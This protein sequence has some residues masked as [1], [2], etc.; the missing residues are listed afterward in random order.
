MKLRLQINKIT[1]INTIKVRTFLNFCKKIQWDKSPEVGLRVQYG[2]EL[3]QLGEMVMFQNEGNYTDKKMF[4][5]ALA[6]FLEDS[7]KVT[8]VDKPP[9]IKYEG[10]SMRKN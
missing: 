9:Y 2:R 7:C 6:A 8:F 5:T 1:I 3:D 4:Q 10:I